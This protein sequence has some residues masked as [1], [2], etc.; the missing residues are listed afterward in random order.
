MDK[1]ENERY[2]EDRTTDSFIINE[3]P[4]ELLQFSISF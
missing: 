4:I 2:N 3:L 1:I